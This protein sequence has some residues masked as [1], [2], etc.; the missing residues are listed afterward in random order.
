MNRKESADKLCA[1]SADQLF[2]RY[3]ITRVADVT[4]LDTIGV[5]VW[6]AIR[7][8]G[9]FISVSG[10]KSLDPHLA[11]ASAIAESIEISIME[12]PPKE[13]PGLVHH[14]LSGQPK[15]VHPDQVWL[16][17]YRSQSEFNRTS[18]GQALGSNIE[19]AILQGLY[20]CI[21]RDQITLRTRME[22]KFGFLPPGVDLREASEAIKELVS[23]CNQAGISVFV[24]YCG[25][26]ISLPVYLAVLVDKSETFFETMGYGT[27]FVPAVAIEKAILE[28]IQA[29]AIYIAGARDDMTRGRFQRA[30]ERDQCA[31][32]KTLR[33][34]RPQYWPDWG[35][36]S[37]KNELTKV[38][39]RLGDWAENILVRVVNGE[40][41]C[42]KVIVE[43]F[44][45]PVTKNWK[46]DEK[47]WDRLNRDFRWPDTLWV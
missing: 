3:G 40:W 47:R 39:E 1:L 35:A 21:E 25:L 38:V 15:R 46:A 12:K 27:N 22:W 8:L 28:A 26:D 23:L 9:H 42:A 24:Y 45:T 34:T 20:E 7:P 11:K 16:N 4:G 30:L 32:D 33:K 19:D 6:S 37:P 41:P 29:R 36:I 43:G 31:V 13:D 18:N 17:L 2:E 44:E 10:G 5:P 14:L